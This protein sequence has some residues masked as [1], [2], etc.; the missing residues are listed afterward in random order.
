M[1]HSLFYTRPQI[2]K[3]GNTIIYLSTNIEGLGKTK[4]LKLLYLLEQISIQKYGFPFFN[5]RFDVWKYGPVSRDIFIDLSNDSVDLLSSY[6]SVEKCD[7][8]TFIRPE[9]AFEDD[10]FS[11]NDLFVLEYVTSHFRNATATQLVNLTHNEHS[12]W[13]HTA[14][15]NGLIEPFALGQINSTDIEIDFSTILT[16]ENQKAFYL[17]NKELLAFGK[18][19][20]H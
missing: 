2:E 12:P 3:I 14:L 19:L 9:K 6:I 7:E 13:Y 17:E 15:K 5:I 20:K 1:V 16:D 18:H 10:E 4:L 8:T 11:D